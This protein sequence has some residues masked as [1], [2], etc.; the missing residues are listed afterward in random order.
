M[1]VWNCI[2]EDPA[3]FGYRRQIVAL[4]KGPKKGPPDAKI[5]SKSKKRIIRPIR[6][7]KEDPFFARICTKIVKFCVVGHKKT[8][9]TLTA[10]GRGKK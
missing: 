4:E 2:I 9:G 1:I 7:N 3:P 6:I 8:F 10:S 5:A